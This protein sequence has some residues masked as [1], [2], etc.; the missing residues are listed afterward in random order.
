M[1]ALPRS[2][3]NR[4]GEKDPSKMQHWLGSPLRFPYTPS[5]PV[6]TTGGGDG[7]NCAAVCV[8]NDKHAIVR[9]ERM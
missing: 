6:H 1:T 4:S 8:A 7:G 5:F 9:R 3:E 2:L